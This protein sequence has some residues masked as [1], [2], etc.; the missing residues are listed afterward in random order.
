MSLPIS[1]WFTGDDGPEPHRARS[2]GADLTIAERFGESRA[3]SPEPTL[4][5][6]PAERFL[7]AVLRLCVDGAKEPA[8]WV[9]SDAPND[10]VIAAGDIERALSGFMGLTTPT[11]AG[12]DLLARVDAE[13][14]KSANVLQVTLGRLRNA[15][16]NP[17][18][19]DD[20]TWKSAMRA[21]L[22]EH[23]EALAGSAPPAKEPR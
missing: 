22:R 5:V 9:P 10:V 1:A 19:G 14:R 13:E 18:D 20:N 17:P 7:A 6:T 3:P 16:N 11:P 23:E 8:T 21:A 4:P 12:C 15:I 2:D